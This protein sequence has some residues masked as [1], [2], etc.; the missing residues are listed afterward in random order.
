MS[1]AVPGPAQEPW[2]STSLDHR[3]RA[4]AMHRGRRMHVGSLGRACGR[5]L[6]VGG[7][8]EQR[9]GPGRAA[10]DRLSLCAV[11]S[12]PSPFGSARRHGIYSTDPMRR[13]SHA[14]KGTWDK[15]VSLCSCGYGLGT[16]GVGMGAGSPVQCARRSPRRPSPAPLRRAG[17]PST[18]FR[19]YIATSLVKYHRLPGH[20]VRRVISRSHRASV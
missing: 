11:P 18:H 3:T 14:Q 16:R 2:G 10:W 5:P 8:R 6:A 9:L 7:A 1:E 13:R 4:Y 20:A 19:K 12:V 17:V 15:H